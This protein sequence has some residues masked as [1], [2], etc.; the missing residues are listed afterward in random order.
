MP[1]ICGVPC[2]IALAY[3]RPL[4]QCVSCWLVP[5]QSDC[6]A[7]PRSPAL[8]GRAAR[9][10]QVCHLL[11]PSA[12]RRVLPPHPA[13]HHPQ[14]EQGQCQE[15]SGCCCDLRC[16]RRLPAC[17]PAVARPARA[18]RLSPPLP[19]A[20]S[21]SPLSPSSPHAG[22]LWG[23]PA[24][25]SG[26]QG[27]GQTAHRLNLQ[28]GWAGGRRG[29]GSSPFRPQPLGGRVPC[30]DACR[31]VL[32]RV[33][34]LLQSVPRVLPTAPSVGPPT[35]PFPSPPAATPSSCPPTA[36]HRPSG[37]SCCTPFAP[38]QALSSRELPRRGGP[39]PLKC[40]RSCR[41]SA[42]L[43]AMPGTQHT[44]LHAQ[45]SPAYCLLLPSFSPAA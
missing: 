34:A 15:G 43:H 11:Q 42:L 24:G 45:I 27:C 12:A 23:L 38:A 41:H 6:C 39:V 13:P 28:V 37:R 33:L 29:A 2:C 10:P 5:A 32:L 3:A 20:L 22:G 19:C 14:G 21:S 25:G 17:L 4:L 9:P 8:A 44:A 30:E 31:R 7:P 26:G 35:H 16:R 40:L 18:R 36:A 1:A